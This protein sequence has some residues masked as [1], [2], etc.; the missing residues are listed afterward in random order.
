LLQW[1]AGEGRTSIRIAT[2]DDSGFPKEEYGVPLVQES[3]V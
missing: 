1:W 2:R 3:G